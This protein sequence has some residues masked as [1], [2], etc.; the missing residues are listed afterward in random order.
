MQ[1]E[2]QQNRGDDKF[3]EKL[4]ALSEVYH[5]RK[6]A[7]AQELGIS[8]AHLSKLLSGENPSLTLQILTD[9]IYKE[10]FLTPD[11]EFL[12]LPLNEVELRGVQMLADAANKEVREFIAGCVN[13]YGLEYANDLRGRTA[14]TGVNRE[15]LKTEKTEA[16][17]SGVNS[18]AVAAAAKASMSAAEK[19]AETSSPSP[20]SRRKP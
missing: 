2:Q 17:I 11:P 7:L 20:K 1:N 18:K 4:I 14:M 6:F 16:R 12:N 19:A 3:K 15:P 13:R 9:R 10:T 8:P 5:R